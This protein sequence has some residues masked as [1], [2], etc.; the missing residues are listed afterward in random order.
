MLSAPRFIC[1]AFIVINGCMHIKLTVKLQ[2]VLYRSVVGFDKYKH[3]L[4]PN[5][6]HPASREDRLRPYFYLVSLFSS[7]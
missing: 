7:G 6:I 2:F 5:L 4:K 3:L 1:L